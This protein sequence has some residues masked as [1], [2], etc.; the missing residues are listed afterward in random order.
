M[1][2]APPTPPP[3]GAKFNAFPEVSQHSWPWMRFL[4]HGQ[5]RGS[6]GLTGEESL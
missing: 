5:H 4:P 6:V 2:T 1:T 3:A